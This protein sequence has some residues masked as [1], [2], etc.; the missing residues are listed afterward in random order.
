[1]KYKSSKKFGKFPSPQGLYDPDHEHDA[2]G[3][4]FVASIDG[5]KSH[6]IIR[7][8]IKVMENLMHRGAIGG[9][10][11]TGDGAGILFQVPDRFFRKECESLGIDLPDP[12][13]NDSGSNGGLY[14]VG[15]FFM[16][17][18]ADLFDKCLKIVEEKVEF[19]GLKFL[20]WRD[21]P[22]DKNAIGG[23][24]AKEQPVIMQCFIDG[25]GLTQS[26]LEIKL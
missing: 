8:G 5:E 10:L 7:N 14:G 17:R 24:A 25:K 2:C 19:E 3:V 6:D 23:Q 22:F 26:A 13:F 18:S 4:G 16:P 21:V 9:D 15:M 12:G 20:G 1:M 11:T